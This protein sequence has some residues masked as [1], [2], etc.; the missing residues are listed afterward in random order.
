[1][2]ALDT[3]VLVRFIVQDDPA[4][5]RAASRLIAKSVRAGTPLFVP[6]TVVLELEWVLR[7]VFGFDETAWSE[8]LS[9]LVAAF[10]LELESEA[11]FEVALSVYES[12]AADFADCLH[13]P[14]PVSAVCSCC[15]P[16]TNRPPRSLARGR[17]LRS[18]SVERMTEDQ[19]KQ[20]ALGSLAD[21]V[22]RSVLS[23]KT[24]Y[25]PRPSSPQIIVRAP[26]RQPAS[27][28]FARLR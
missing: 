13:S 22:K 19:L 10:D 27:G 17:C 7:S 26:A 15:G 14:L 9:Q 20:E 21:I 3:N 2:A 23:T 6:I 25:S 18:E 1:M 28:T 12:S 11:A 16:S 4:Q 5:S 8:M 24:H